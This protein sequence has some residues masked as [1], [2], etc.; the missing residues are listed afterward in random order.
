LPL[1]ALTFSVSNFI[2]TQAGPR[3]RNQIID[4][5]IVRV[6]PQVKLLEES[7]SPDQPSRKVLPTRQQLRQ[8]VQDFL[9]LTGSGKVGVY[10]VLFFIFLALSMLITIEHTFNDIWEIKKG[11]PWLQ[12]VSV[13]WSI[14]TLG[15]ILLI[16]AIV[17]TGRWQATYVAQ[18]IQ[19][20]PYV[21][22]L[23]SFITPFVIFWLGLTFTYMAMPNTK[24]SLWA[25][26]V[27]GVTAGTLLQLNNLLNTMYVYTV[28]SYQE[29]Y[30]GLGVLPIL[31]VGLY[32]FWF[33]IL[34]GGQLTYSLETTAER[35]QAQHPFPD[36]LS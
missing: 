9:E 11:R 29:F 33:I 5:V 25:A 6:I 21:S 17:L 7:R 10:G 19:E 24:V 14:M 23:L 36:R 35:F 1:L 15:L 2:L 18:Q 28:A 32:V 3:E 26:S 8:Q 4:R 20:I 16:V 12:R 13:Y 30:G 22:R 27:G 31:L 34:C